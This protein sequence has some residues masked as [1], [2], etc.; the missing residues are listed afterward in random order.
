M[1]HGREGSRTVNR[2]S[3]VGAVGVVAALCLTVAPPAQARETAKFKLLS[4]AGSTTST[5]DVVYD[6]NPYGSC[7]FTQAERISFQSTKRVT[8]YAFTSKAHGRA[9]VA[10]SSKPE[11]SG[12]FSVVEVPGK[13]TVSRSATYEQTEGYYDPDLGGWTSGCWQEYS[14]VDCSVERTFPAT[15][16]IGGTSGGDE[17]TYV[18]L[19]PDRAWDA[20]DAACWVE[21][22]DPGGVEPG[23]FARAALFKRRPKRL[24]DTDRT[25]W[26]TFDYPDDGITDVGATVQELSA[27]LKRKKIEKAA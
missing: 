24:G 23:L 14:P 13:V 8:A 9:R 12:N 19:A 27:E 25:E 20:I 2:R 16:Q 10:W 7:S 22:V 5:R 6:P 18:V 11:Y 17:S 26:P 15:L 4:A 21:F 1:T 3:L